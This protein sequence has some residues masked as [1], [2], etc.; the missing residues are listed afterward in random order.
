MTSEP[1][2]RGPK[3]PSRNAIAGDARRILLAIGRCERITPESGRERAKRG[4]SAIQKRGRD[5][6]Y[7]RK[8]GSRS[9]S[10]RTGLPGAVVRR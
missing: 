2:E 8:A 10:E 5:A 6:R 9:M 4:A 1:K 3:Q 7:G